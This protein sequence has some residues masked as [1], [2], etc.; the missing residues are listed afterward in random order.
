MNFRFE[1]RAEHTIIIENLQ[2]LAKNVLIW[3]ALQNL[4]RPAI[5]F[6]TLH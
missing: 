6:G 5:H 4:R 1:H 2:K 3:L